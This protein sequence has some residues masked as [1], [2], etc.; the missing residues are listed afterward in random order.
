MRMRRM[1]AA[2]ML[3]A[4][5]TIGAAATADAMPPRWAQSCTPDERGA[6]SVWYE[7]YVMWEGFW[8]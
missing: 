3:A 7:L 1:A 5:F 4:M 6:C 2:A 8:N